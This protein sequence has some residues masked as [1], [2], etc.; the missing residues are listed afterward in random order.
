MISENFARSEFACPCCGLDTVDAELLRLLENIRAHFDA[1]I[2]VTSSYRCKNH[3][4]SVGGAATSQHLYGRAADIVV[5]GVEPALVAELADQL[6][7]GGVGT[8]ET[9]THV[10]TRTNG[11][12][13]GEAKWL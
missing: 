3:N 8:Y 9:F 7:A 11:N 2:T 10:D 13:E 12:P 1:P 5:S 4:Q 6:G